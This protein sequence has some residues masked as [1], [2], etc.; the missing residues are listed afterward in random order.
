M[1]VLLVQDISYL[2]VLSWCCLRSGVLE[3]LPRFHNGLLLWFAAVKSSIDSVLPA[4]GLGSVR[5]SRGGVWG[6]I[7]DLRKQLSK[8]DRLKVTRDK[9]VR[10]GQ[11][12]R[13]AKSM[14]S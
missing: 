1:Y 10:D 5:P 9:T 12:R 8:M 4:A 11:R 7:A 2:F 3:C 13:R 14:N 6:V